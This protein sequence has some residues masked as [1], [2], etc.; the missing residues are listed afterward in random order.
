MPYKEF[1]AYIFVSNS[2]ES[3]FLDY[4]ILCS[5][6]YRVLLLFHRPDENGLQQQVEAYYI[7]II[8]FEELN[9]EGSDTVF[10]A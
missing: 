3:E 5:V 7:I 6:L 8:A 1:Y 2:I 4:Q 9:D 10:H